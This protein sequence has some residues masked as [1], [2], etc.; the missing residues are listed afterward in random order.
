MK[1]QLDP[2]STG[3]VEMTSSEMAHVLLRHTSLSHSL[4]VFL[5]IAIE[6]TA[7]YSSVVSEKICINEV[8]QMNSAHHNDLVEVAYQLTGLMF[9]LTHTGQYGHRLFTLTEFTNGKPMARD[10]F[11]AMNSSLSWGSNAHRQA[12]RELIL[13][14]G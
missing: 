13:A 4:I 14:E 6:D 11:D 8:A 2:L 3:A 10:R 7:E 5:A 9:K 12:V 1:P